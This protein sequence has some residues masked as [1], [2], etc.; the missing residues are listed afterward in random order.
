MVTQLPASASV[1]FER[2]SLECPSALAGLN[3]PP[4]PMAAAKPGVVGRPNVG[5]AA[6]ALLPFAEDVY[7]DPGRARRDGERPPGGNGDEERGVS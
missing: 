3:P 2:V 1:I 6:L 4:L 5:E 7:N